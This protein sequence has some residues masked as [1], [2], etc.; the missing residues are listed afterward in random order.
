MK[1]RPTSGYVLTLLA[2][3]AVC[4]AL[5]RGVMYA[6]D[7]YFMEMNR[8]EVYK[9]AD[10]YGGY[11]RIL[12]DFYVRKTKAITYNITRHS[13]DMAWFQSRAKAMSLDIPGIESII[14]DS[15]DGKIREYYRTDMFSSENRPVLEAA[16]HKAADTSRQNMDIAMS[17][18]MILNDGSIVAVI[19]YPVNI[20]D[21]ASK[22][23]VYWG[24][25]LEIVDIAEI[26]EA[27][28]LNEL[29]KNGYEWR[30]RS[31]SGNGSENLDIVGT[32]D[33]LQLWNEENQR[34]RDFDGLEPVSAVISMPDG[35]WVLQ[36]VPKNGWAATRNAFKENV[37]SIL[38]ALFVMLIV[39]SLMRLR[40]QREDMEKNATTDSLTGLGNRLAFEVAL[41][42]ECRK[43]KGH[44]L[45]AYMDLDGFKQVNDLYGHDAGDQILK[46]VA[47]RILSVLKP[48]DK[49]FRVTGDEFL[50][51][52]KPEQSGGW[53]N[54]LDT[55][56]GEVERPFELESKTTVKVG[57]SIGCALYP[58]NAMNPKDLVGLGDQRMYADKNQR[59]EKMNEEEQNDES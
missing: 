30:M 57:I 34:S 33:G 16:F 55:V 15:A 37:I 59:K 45:L 50:A 47:R 31:L 40:H 17:G 51:I 4:F 39:N 14:A 5:V 52:L 8:K 32:D 10:T 22:Q 24:D 21:N 11:I 42:E 46:G 23:F 26:V 43:F 53:K 35:Q 19:A 12:G 44:F 13:D 36:V 1:N 28:N 3:F 41:K 7:Q 20:F 58:Q 6:A 2:V 38:L 27:A 18:P 54:R 25:C 29:R 9:L 49:L 48:E 56:R